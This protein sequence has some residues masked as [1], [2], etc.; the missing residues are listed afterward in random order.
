MAHTA[1]VRHTAAMLDAA[2]VDQLTDVQVRALVS[3]LLSDL[4]HK[5]ATID[6]LTHELAVLRRVRFGVKSEALSAGQRSLFEES[7]DEDLAAL[8]ERLAQLRAPAADRPRGQAKRLPLPPNLPRREICHEPASTV[9]HCGCALRRIG[10]DV[11]ERLDYEPGRFQ[12]ERHVR[13]K[14]VCG[15]CRTLVQAPVPPQVIDKGLPSAGLLAHVLVAKYADHLPLYRQEAI[16][17]RAGV[18]L[19]R[20]TLAQWVGVCGVQLQPLVDALKT[21]L[22]ARPVLHADE[23]PVPVLDPGAGKTYRATLWSYASTAFDGLRGVV[24]D[25]AE[26][27]GAEHPKTFLGAWRGTLVCDDYAGYKALFGT[28]IGEA[29]CLAHARRKFH[30]LHVAGKSTLAKQALLLIGRLYE[31]EREVKDLDPDER[32]RIRQSQARPIADDLHAWLIAQRQKL[33]D[34]SATARAIDYSLKRWGPLTRYLDDGDLPIDNN[35]VENRI[36]P[37]ALGRANWLFAG[38]LAAGQRAAAVMSLIGSAKM[39][40]FDPYAYL[41]DVLERLPSHPMRRI[42]ELLPHRWQPAKSA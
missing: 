26:T 28:N 21:A 40:G 7:V 29:G 39:N 9:C 36:R 34:G 42:E 6:K 30:E 38:T 13:G 23:T 11:A 12:V 15:A 4:R 22:L 25:L 1:V 17:A 32:R 20:S 10:E 19:S 33:P 8:E 31:V 16:Y 41:K 18:A 24:F 35:W 27:R 5:Q 37:I 3:Q 14:W 2:A